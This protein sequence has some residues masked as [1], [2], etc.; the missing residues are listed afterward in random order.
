VRVFSRKKPYT[1]IFTRMIYHYKVKKLSLLFFRL[2]LVVAG[3]LIVLLVI[4]TIFA[5]VRSRD[6]EPLFRLGGQPAQRNVNISLNNDI[7]VFSGLGRLRIPLGNSST[8]I[9]S[10]AFPYSSDDTAFTEELAGKI[11]EFRTIA[12]GYFSSLPEEKLIQIDEDAAKHEILRRFNNSLRLGRINA[13]YFSD[14]MV[15]DAF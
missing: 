5:L 1:D 9:L 4:G 2:L 11:N 13:L 6:A 15:I 14:M 3:V 10:I 7:Q 12:T 8:L